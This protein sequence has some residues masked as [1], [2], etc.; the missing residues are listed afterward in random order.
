MKSLHGRALSLAVT[1]ACSAWLMTAPA[2][3]AQAADCP[4]AGPAVCGENSG[5]VPVHKDFIHA[6]LIWNQKY[7]TCPR[8]L[9]WMRPSEYKPKHYLNPPVPGG[10]FPGFNQKYIDLVQ[11]T[12]LHTTPGGWRSAESRLRSMT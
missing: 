8:M 12:S 9:I 11:G 2:G 5:L 1:G 6:S 10:G 7:S 3:S 4:A